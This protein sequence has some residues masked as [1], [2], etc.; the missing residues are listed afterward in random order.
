LPSPIIDETMHIAH[1]PEKAGRPAGI[2]SEPT[3]DQS[4]PELARGPHSQ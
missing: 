4:Q 2:S 3:L 1:S